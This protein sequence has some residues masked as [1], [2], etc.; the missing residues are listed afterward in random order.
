MNRD[1]QDAQHIDVSE[2]GIITDKYASEK[3][4]NNVRNIVIAI[5]VVIAVGFIT[6]VVQVG[7]DVKHSFS[8]TTRIDLLNERI[9]LILDSVVVQRLEK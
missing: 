9:N 4:L 3:D 7:L 1:S 8:E 6:L 2:A 5:G